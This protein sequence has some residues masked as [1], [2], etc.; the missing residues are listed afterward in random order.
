VYPQEVERV[1]VELDGVADAAVVGAPDEQTVQAVRAVI[2]RTPDGEGL[3]ADAVRVHCRAQLA[4]FK[5]PTQV[6]FVDALPRTP[7]GRVARHLLARER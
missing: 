7:S 4:R 3:D 5:T 1:L 2:V 6:V